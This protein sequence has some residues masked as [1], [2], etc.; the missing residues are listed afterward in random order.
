[1]TDEKK[2]PEGGAKANVTNLTPVE[3]ISPPS[4]RSTNVMMHP[5]VQSVAAFMQQTLPADELRAVANAIAAVAPII[6]SQYAEQRLRPIV[7]SEPS[8][9]IS[10]S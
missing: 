9:Q 8:V 3:T 7:L 4:S 6:W 2:P 5:S 1:M 10:V